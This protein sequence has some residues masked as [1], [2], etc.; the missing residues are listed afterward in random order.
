[1]TG[2]LSYIVLS[3]GSMCTEADLY[4]TKNQSKDTG[5]CTHRTIYHDHVEAFSKDKSLGTGDSDSTGLK[6]GL[7]PCH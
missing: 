2:C 5:T 7:G 6:C 4:K 1:M 3:G